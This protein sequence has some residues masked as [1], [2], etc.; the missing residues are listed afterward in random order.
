M[1]YKLSFVWKTVKPFLTT[2]NATSH[3]THL[4]ITVHVTPLAE[5]RW[6]RRFVRLQP[7]QCLLWHVSSLPIWVE[8]GAGLPTGMDGHGSYPAR[9]S[10]SLIGARR[11]SLG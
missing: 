10:I 1:S 6:H 3:L 11:K 7:G 5:H 2:Q 4:N 8:A 9:A